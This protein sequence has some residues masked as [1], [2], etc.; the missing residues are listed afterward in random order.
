M[1]VAIAIG[2]SKYDVGTDLPGCAR[3]ITLMRGIIAHSHKFEETLIIDSDA[4]STSVKTA[5]SD[6]VQRLQS[7]TIEDVL[8][9]FT[10]HGDFDGTQFFYNFSD[11]DR[12][13]R[14][15][16]GWTNTEIDEMI[17]SLN[18]A[19]TVKIIDAC[20]SGEYYI[21]D[22]EAIKKALQDDTQ[23][24]GRCYF[25]FSSQHDQ[26]SFQTNT[27]SDFTLSI[28]Q[29]ILDRGEGKLRYRDVMDHVSDE[30][31]QSSYQRPIFIVQASNTE[32]FV[33]VDGEMIQFVRG[34]VGT[35]SELPSKGAQK[36]SL[37]E[38]ARRKAEELC[39]RDEVQRQLSEFEQL[40]S[41]WQASPPLDDLYSIAIARL[42]DDEVPRSKEIGTWLAENDHDLFARPTTK[43]VIVQRLKRSSRMFAAIKGLS[44]VDEPSDSDYESVQE[45]RISGYE[46]TEDVEYYGSVILYT[47]QFKS[48]DRLHCWV[49][50]LF[51]AK[52]LVIFYT[53]VID[54]LAGFDRY[55]R[56]ERGKWRVSTCMI[57]NNEAIEAA[58]DRIIGEMNTI[59]MANSEAILGVDVKNE[60]NE[61]SV[62]NSP[63]VATA[64]R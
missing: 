36:H 40:V 1:N 37:V 32:E 18:P 48:L 50:V 43:K 23:R 35:P 56:K 5:V 6:F 57:R 34:I 41:H 53:H 38:S 12:K 24:L 52:T 7:E 62:D 49:M 39:D 15:S 14:N 30:F 10:G 64:E 16:T 33:H 21:K 54:Q 25:M 9:Y 28:G 55:E 45:N 61:D 26:S 4:R 42:E 63:E 22:D 51:S 20:H 58:V 31:E 8:F 60:E 59:L 44:G 19:L 29:S 3:D 27:I 2:V 17:R 11:Y 47:P 13:R 46:R